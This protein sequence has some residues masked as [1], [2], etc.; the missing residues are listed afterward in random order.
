MEFIEMKSGLFFSATASL[1]LLGSTAVF[2]QSY[3]APGAITLKPGQIQSADPSPQASVY[4]SQPDVGIVSL[5][6]GETVNT[7]ASQDFGSVQAGATNTQEGV[8]TLK[9]GQAG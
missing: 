6:P 1:M 5:K 8:I 2:A 3:A 7:A 9:P 4:A